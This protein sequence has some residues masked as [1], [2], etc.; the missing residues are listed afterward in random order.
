MLYADG[1]LGKSF[2]SLHVAIQAARGGQAFLGRR[3][4][5]EPLISLYLDWELDIDEISRRA[6]E[7]ARGFE[8]SK[9]PEGL[10]Y[11]TP[12]SSLYK[13]LK[14]LPKLVEREKTEFLSI[15]SIGAAGVDPDKVMDVVDVFT[16]LR[17]LS[18][19]TL[20]VDH[21]SK[22]QSNDNYDSKTPYGSVYKYNL[23]RSVFHFHD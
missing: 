22:M 13:F 21:Q 6:D 20:P 17:N 19:T 11:Y 15:D 9:P 23:S 4:L 16:A 18:V 2:F 12:K 10:H 3:F 8:L 5:K 14:E 7:I 1:G